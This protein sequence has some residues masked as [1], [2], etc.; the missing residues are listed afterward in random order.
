[1]GVHQ[2]IIRT[3]DFD[4]TERDDLHTAPGLDPLNNE[5]R[6]FWKRKCSDYL[7]VSATATTDLAT[8]VTSDGLK[9]LTVQNLFLD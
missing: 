1:L 2:A 5:S 7:K 3:I 8:T 4:G 9:F 6:E